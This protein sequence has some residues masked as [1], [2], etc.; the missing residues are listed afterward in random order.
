MVLSET[1]K[2][3]IAAGLCFDPVERGYRAYF[4]SIEDLIHV[5]KMKDITRTAATE[6]K[7]IMKSHLLV[8]D[9]IMMFPATRQDVVAFFN[10]V[11]ELH[12]KTSLV[13]TTNK[14]PKEWAA[15]IKDKVL[16]T[17]LLD[18]L[19]HRCEVIKLSG[20]SFRMKNRKTFFN[21]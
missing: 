7:R 4:M 2:T 19:L 8:I 5:L 12:D 18:R 20:S 15:V 14:S 10:L 16:P 1:G 11:N 9:D 3:H 6:Y 17:K 21:N 13:I